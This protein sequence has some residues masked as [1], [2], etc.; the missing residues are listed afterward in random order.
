MTLLISPPGG[1]NE[2][3]KTNKSDAAILSQSILQTANLLK[4]RSSKI[5]NIKGSSKLYVVFLISQRI[6]LLVASSHV[7]AFASS[8]P[9]ACSN[10][11]SSSTSDASSS[12]ELSLSNTPTQ[13]VNI[14][15]CVYI[16]KKKIIVKIPSPLA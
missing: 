1:K 4:N 8:S 9:Q 7:S 15:E 16:F 14:F 6:Y 13:K 5:V 11:S 10:S 2:L 3:N 12:D